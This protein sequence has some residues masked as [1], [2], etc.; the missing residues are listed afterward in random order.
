MLMVP[1][2]LLP[3]FV[4]LIASAT[5]A[6]SGASFAQSMSVS[7]TKLEVS[8]PS[9]QTVLIIKAGGATISVVQARVMAWNENDDPA[10]M[11][12]T[13]NVVISPPAAQLKPGQEL[14]L[15]IV[16]VAKNPVVKKECYRVLIDRLPGTERTGKGIKLQIRHSIPLC[17]MP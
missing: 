6:T 16:R 8:A 1:N 12:L 15:R 17:F 5:L 14:S 4:A 10:K 13:R 2:C 9:N 11:T 3:M 7:P